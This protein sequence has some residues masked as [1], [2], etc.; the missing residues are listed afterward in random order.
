MRRLT[1]D[2]PDDNWSTLLNY[3]YPGEDHFARIRHDGECEGV[4]LLQWIRRQCVAR[5]CDE[6]PGVT[7]EEI[8]GTLSGCMM[9]GEGCPIALA[10]TFA[11]QAVHLRD[12]LKRIEDILGDEYDLDR[13]QAWGKAYREGRMGIFALWPGADAW[14][15]ERGEEDE[16]VDV[17]GFV[18]L[19]EVMGMAILSPTMGDDGDIDYI[20]DALAGETAEFDSSDVYVYPMSDVYPTY[21]AAKAALEAR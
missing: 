6:F 14:V 3:V 21:E 20:M 19:A 8:D 17:A 10:Y 2:H 4:S 13:L 9:D 5:G 15:V 12:R 7:N 1:T 11:C 16:P 18:F